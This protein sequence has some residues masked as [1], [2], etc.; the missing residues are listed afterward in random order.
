VAGCDPI[1]VKKSITMAT[2]RTNPLIEGLSGM[3]GQSIVFKNLRGKTIITSRPS[4][5]KKQSELQKANRSKFRQATYYAKA[6]MLDAEKKA[7]YQ[8]KAKKLKLPNAY[9]AAITDYMRPVK[10]K[11]TNRTNTTVTYRITKRDFD[12]K[13]VETL[14]VL[15]ESITISTLTRLNYNE[16]ELKLSSE[17]LQVGIQVIVTDNTHKKRRWDLKG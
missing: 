17:I 5:P 7:Y 2:I 4:P 14:P 11:E 15:S 16:W 10:L 1:L 3:L 13:Q 12:V 8:K 6:A 9:T